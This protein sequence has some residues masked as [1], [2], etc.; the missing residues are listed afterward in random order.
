METKNTQFEYRFESQNIDKK[1]MNQHNL[2][3]KNKY[4]LDWQR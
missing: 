4:N 3:L 1:W 2:K